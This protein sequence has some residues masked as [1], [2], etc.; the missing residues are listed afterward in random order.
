MEFTV[1]VLVIAAIIVLSLVVIGRRNPTDLS[2]LPIEEIVDD[3]RTIKEEF[4]DMQYKL[5]AFEEEDGTTGVYVMDKKT[6][7]I[8]AYT[9]GEGLKAVKQGGK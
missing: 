5:T 8:L 4:F 1:V 3:N 7:A 9:V 6:H 2:D